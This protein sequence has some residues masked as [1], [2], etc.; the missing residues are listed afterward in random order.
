MA[1]FIVIVDLA[2]AHDLATIFVYKWLFSAVAETV[3]GEASEPERHAVIGLESAIFGTSVSER[4]DAV[5]KR[6]RLRTEAAPYS[7][8]PD[9]VLCV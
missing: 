9:D 5:W 6:F 4:F 8:H 1:Q 2:V 7:T 3:D